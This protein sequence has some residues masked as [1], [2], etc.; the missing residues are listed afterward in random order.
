MS[1]PFRNVAMMSVRTR[2]HRMLW[3]TLPWV[4]ASACFF[5]SSDNTLPTQVQV[6][7]GSILVRVVTTGE[8]LDPDGYTVA[9]DEDRSD[10]VGANG[11]VEFD[12]LLAG[13]YEVFLTDFA[14]NCV[15]TTP[16]PASA[17]VI[18][19]AVSEI[20]FSVTCTVS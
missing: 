17:T 19:D 11:M 3:A 1:T 9:I 5:T 13:S 2:I 7:F 6:G 18:K 10:T 4:G 14:E 12:P 16:N 15:V 20:L 8:M